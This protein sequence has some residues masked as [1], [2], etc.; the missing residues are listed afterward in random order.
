MCVL[1]I[2]LGSGGTGTLAMTAGC[3]YLGVN[4]TILNPD[5]S[6]YPQSPT[7][8]IAYPPVVTY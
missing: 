7:S 1:S 8:P 5:G 3:G 2:L 6:W 4:Y